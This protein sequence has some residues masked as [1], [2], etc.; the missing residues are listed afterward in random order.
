MFQNVCKFQG[1]P[2]ANRQASLVPHG[3]P[4]SV[5]LRRLSS[6]IEHHLQRDVRCGAIVNRRNEVGPPTPIAPMRMV[7]D[8]EAPHNSEAH[9]LIRLCGRVEYQEGSVE[10]TR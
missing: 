9:D 6:V 8:L 3:H 4:T 2:F 1:S 5:E 10:L 7:L